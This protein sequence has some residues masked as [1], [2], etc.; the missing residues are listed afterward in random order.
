MRLGKRNAGIV[1]G[2]LTRRHNGLSLM[3]VILALAI[4]GISLAT[5]GQLVRIGMRHAEEARALG[6]AQLLCESKLE[7]IA[8]TA[9]PCQSASGVCETDDRWQY[10]V[11]TSTLDQSGLLEVRVTVEQVEATRNPPLSFSLVRWMIDP[12]TPTSS[13]TSQSAGSTSASGGTSS[14]GTTSGGSNATAR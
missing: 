4:L 8:A 1:M 10:T 3:E 13:T 11:S 7:E 5:L 9:A 2:R 12:S 14:P 6:T